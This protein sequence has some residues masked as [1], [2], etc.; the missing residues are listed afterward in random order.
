VDWLW[1]W[2]L[3]AFQAI[4]RGWHRDWLDPVFTAI[5]YLGVGQVQVAIALLC[6]ISRSTRR[7][8]LPMLVVF[9]ASG[10]LNNVVKRLTERQRPSN[11]ALALAQE[12]HKYNSFPSGHSVTSFAIAFLILVSTWGTKRVWIGWSALGL[13]VL[14]GLSR[15]YRGVHWP[16][17]VIG[18]AGLGLACAA[19]LC[20]TPLSP[21][22]RAEAGDGRAQ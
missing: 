14:V 13:A 3:N 20:M 17:D 1:H 12:P 22:E 9:A 11:L 21:R 5:T 2:D 10:L 15:V 7:F 4:N 19:V 18:A 6:L 8:A 16:T